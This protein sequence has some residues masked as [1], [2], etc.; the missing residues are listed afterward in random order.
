MRGLRF[1]KPD[2]DILKVRKKENGSVRNRRK[3]KKRYKFGGF[4]VLIKLKEDTC[5][6]KHELNGEE[7]VTQMFLMT[8]LTCL[9]PF[10]GVESKLNP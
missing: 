7:V 3:K 9:S 2:S 4:E 10:N 5:L 1:H 6:K 8:H